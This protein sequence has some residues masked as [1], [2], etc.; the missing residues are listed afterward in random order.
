MSWKGILGRAAVAAVLA[1]VPA[2]VNAQI[3]AWRDA[4]GNLVLSDKAKNP[5]A[6]SYAVTPA[7]GFRTTRPVSKRAAQYEHLIR[8]HSLNQGISPDLVRAV[9]QAESAFNPNARS[10]K[11]A[12]GLMQLMPG[13][14]AEYGVNNPYDPAENIRAGVQY[15]KRLLVQYANNVELALAA[16]NAGPGAVAKYG[17]KV[18]PYRETRNYVAKVKDHA[19]AQGPIVSPTKVYRTVEIINGREVVRY[20]DSRNPGKDVVKT[21]E[22]R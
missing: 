16:Y 10:H 8:Q 7:G 9:I 14:C 4:A 1:L 15:L 18:P 20:T 19:T 6:Q 5:T 13:T 11:G 2:T 17:T 12:M 21:A 3:Y 22:R